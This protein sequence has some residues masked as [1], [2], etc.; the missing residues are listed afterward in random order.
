MG[1]LLI[2]RMTIV[3][4]V[5]MIILII[6]LTRINLRVDNGHYLIQKLILRRSLMM[7][8]ENNYLNVYIDINVFCIK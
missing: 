3:D 7:K 1:D 5:M 8:Y 2:I 6:S 4:S